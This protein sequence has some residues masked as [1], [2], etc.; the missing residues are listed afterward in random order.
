MVKT[1]LITNQSLVYLNICSI[2]IYVSYDIM[3]YGYIHM[4][5]YQIHMY[6]HMKGIMNVH[7]FMCIT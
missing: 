4:Y 1:Y 6:I 3:N 2:S 7:A 5:T